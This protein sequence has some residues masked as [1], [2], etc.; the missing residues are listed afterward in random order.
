MRIHRQFLVAF[1]SP[2]VLNFIAKTIDMPQYLTAA[3]KN[4]DL[5]AY[6]EQYMQ[7]T[8]PGHPSLKY[9]QPRAGAG[10]IFDFK[11][12]KLTLKGLHTQA[13]PLTWVNEERDT[14]ILKFSPYG[15][16][17]FTNV[18]VSQWTNLILPAADIFGKGLQDLYVMIEGLDFQGRIIA[19]EDFFMNRLN[20]GPNEVEKYI[21][22]IADD[23]RKPGDFSF[24]AVRKG[25]PMSKRS[26][27][28]RFKD[29]IGTNLSTYSR[30]CRFERTQ[31]RLSAQ[32]PSLTSIAY[33]GG[34]FDPAHFSR[35]FKRISSVA[36]KNYS[37][38]LLAEGIK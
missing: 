25:I 33:D 26:L 21:F 17:R 3:C 19:V 1:F 15:L 27:E 22:K 16:N 13:F 30:I 24:D 9:I 14:L 32:P 31:Q 23:M 7:L 11:E 12:M 36:P 18:S 10:L 4:I 28:R 29:I 34:Y 38:C 35:D 5:S 2:I 6:I 8:G 37:A 20:S